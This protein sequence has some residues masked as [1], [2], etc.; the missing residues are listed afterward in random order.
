MLINGGLSFASSHGMARLGDPAVLD[1]KRNVA[2][3]A[4][5]E[6]SAAPPRRRQAIEVT[7]QDGRNLG[8]RTDAVRGTADHSMSRDE[9][10]AKAFELLAPVLSD[11]RARRLID[12]IWRIEQI[13]QLRELRPMLEA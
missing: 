1:L 13:D 8:H 5:R 12:R 6:L 10:A 11:E 4:D 2:L 7:T 9:V 3:V